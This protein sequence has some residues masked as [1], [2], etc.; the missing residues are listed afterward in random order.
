MFAF[1]KLID[2][3]L[4]ENYLPLTE[5]K[6][7]S[8]YMQQPVGD[9]FPETNESRPD[10]SALLEAQFIIIPTITLSVFQ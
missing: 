5:R 1:E 2:P 10:P 9:P 3:Q 4:L 8:P 7:S 6:I